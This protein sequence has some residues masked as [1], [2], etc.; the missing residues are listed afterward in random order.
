MASHDD[1]PGRGGGVMRYAALVLVIG[2]ALPASAQESL[3]VVESLAL[4][5]QAD[6]AR[7]A[8]SSWWE[9]QRLRSSRR[10]RQNGLWLRAI[11][12]VDPRLAGLDFQRLVLEYPGGPYSDEALFRLGLISAASEDL[13]RAAGYFRTLVTDY[14]RSGQ[15][16]LAQDWLAEHWVAIEE[17]EAA[18]AVV[19]D[20]EEDALESGVD[21]VQPEVDT[22]E[23]ALDATEPEVDAVEPEVVARR[24]AVIP[25][26]AEDPNARYAVQAGAFESEERA[27][28]LLASV[29]ASGFR[30]RMV[31][32]VGSPLVRVRIG[33]FLDRSGAVELMSRVRGRGHEAT[34]TEDVGREEPIR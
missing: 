4:A 8:L 1:V 27:R 29:N 10:E 2:V 34:L 3:D 26:R 30:A 32:V 5:G 23:F 18:L 6:E 17:A 20:R 33:A 11:L 13:P 21:A 31:R 9:D 22:A 7:T 16:R 15:R 24:P 19:T 28:N 14:P 25:D 12:T